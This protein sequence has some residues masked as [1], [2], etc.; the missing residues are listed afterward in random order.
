MQKTLLRQKVSATSSSLP[1]YTLSYVTEIEND[2]DYY[3]PCFK[4]VVSMDKD[5]SCL[6]DGEMLTGLR[7]IIINQY[8]THS[9]TSEGTQIL[10]SLIKADSVYGHELQA[11][12]GQDI[13][14]N[15]TSAL[16][17]SQ[18]R[19]VL[20]SNY[21]DLDVNVTASFVEAFLNSIIDIR[22]IN[23]DSIAAGKIQ[24]ILVYMEHHLQEPFNIEEIALL[25]NLSTDRVRHLF[26]AQ[27]GFSMVQ[28]LSWRRIK[29]ILSLSKSQ[30]SSLT[31][32]CLKYGYNDQSH[33][34]HTFKLILG[35]KPREVLRS[36]RIVM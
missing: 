16:M 7:A 28:Y 4:V 20:P 5:F 8:M 14:L 21:M 36:F 25:V 17:P 19:H 24:A 35:L 27:M 1:D 32:A 9:F 11:L 26:T 23:K 31:E 2:K 12:L 15:L 6:I 22:Y 30:N 3:H 10:V 18:L 34:N 13:C 33:F 29:N